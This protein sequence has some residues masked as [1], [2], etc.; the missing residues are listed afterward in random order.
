MPINF[1]DFIVHGKSDHDLLSIPVDEQRGTFSIQVQDGSLGSRILRWL[2][3]ER[4]HGHVAIVP[5]TVDVERIAGAIQALKPGYDL[6]L[7]KRYGKDLVEGLKQ[8]VAPDD[9]GFG[10]QVADL[11]ESLSDLEEELHLVSKDLGKRWDTLAIHI[12]EKLE[13][14]GRVIQNWG[15][16]YDELKNVFNNNVGH[17]LWGRAALSNEEIAKLL[18]MEN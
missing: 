14:Q 15:A 2:E 1:S 13:P 18:I 9:A 7:F 10:Q 17:S 3:G 8:T 11:L 5:T 4:A 12:T 16:H 6:D